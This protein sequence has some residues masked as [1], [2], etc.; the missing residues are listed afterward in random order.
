[1]SKA[2]IEVVNK[3]YD[4][5]GVTFFWA[6]FPP[7]KETASDRNMAQAAKAAG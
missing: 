4:A 7:D 5:Y 1:M 6:H 3:F 2:N